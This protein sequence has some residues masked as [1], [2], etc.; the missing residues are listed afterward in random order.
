L[1]AARVRVRRRG[2]TRRRG[3]VL[4]ILF[5]SNSNVDECVKH[6]SKG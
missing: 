1:A 6:S 3:R 2:R 4:E 5:V